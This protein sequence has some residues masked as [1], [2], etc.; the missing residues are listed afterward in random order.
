MISTDTLGTLSITKT[1]QQK[2]SLARSLSIGFLQTITL[3]GR[4]LE[5][6]AKSKTSSGA[7]Q[8]MHSKTVSVI[9]TDYSASNDDVLALDILDDDAIAADQ[10]KNINTVICTHVLEHLGD[11]SLAVN[12]MINLLSDESDARLIILTPFMH[13]IHSDPYD[14]QRLTPDFYTKLLGERFEYVS[15]TLLSVGPLSDNL[16]RIFSAIA[17]R[18]R[19]LLSLMIAPVLILER[20]LAK[21]FKPKY[22]KYRE[23]YPLAIGVIARNKKS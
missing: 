4:V 14:F 15:I 11:P 10:F 16:Y 5:I 22:E 9:L 17:G 19:M 18:Q 21:V 12:N 20:G 3:E 8:C 2:L 13:R 7:L 23:L 6:G 1:I